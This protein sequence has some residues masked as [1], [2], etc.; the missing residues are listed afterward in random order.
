LPSSFYPAAAPHVVTQLATV[1][2]ARE[3][4][5]AP[6]ALRPAS[7]RQKLKRSYSRPQAVAVEH[8]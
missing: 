8:H 2:I 5:R 3:A 1:G 4:T 6:P 7:Q